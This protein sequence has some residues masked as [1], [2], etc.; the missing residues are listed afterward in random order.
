[1]ILVSLHPGGHGTGRQAHISGG[2]ATL[3]SSHAGRSRAD[4]DGRKRGPSQ[5]DGREWLSEPAGPT[6]LILTLME[7]VYGSARVERGALT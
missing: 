4:P 6:G 2:E 5:Q 7:V 3:L 1:M